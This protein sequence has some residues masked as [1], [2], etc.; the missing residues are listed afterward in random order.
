MVV[1][2][3]LVHVFRLRDSVPVILCPAVKEG[4]MDLKASTSEEKKL[5]CGIGVVA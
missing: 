4:S 5:S 3:G 1:L 2:A